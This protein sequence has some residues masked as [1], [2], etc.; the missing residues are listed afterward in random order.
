M[1]EDGLK[2]CHLSRSTL[3]TTPSFLTH[4]KTNMN[5]TDFY[6]PPFKLDDYDECIV[7]MGDE[8][9]GLTWAADFAS[10]WSEGH[11][12]DLE[13]KKGIVECLNGNKKGFI[14]KQRLKVG[15]V[16]LY[17]DGQLLMWARG[18]GEL[19]SPNCL[20]LDGDSAA[21]LQDQFIEHIYNCIS[22]L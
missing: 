18:W 8:E 1:K 12:F 9:R 15:D 21:K 2:V 14:D 3:P 13:L 16:D 7:W 6:K 11:G 4:S 17:L 20:G 22:K 10:D 5:F 19:T